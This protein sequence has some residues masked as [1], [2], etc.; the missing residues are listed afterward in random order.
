M[1][2]DPVPILVLAFILVWVLLMYVAVDVACDR[3]DEWVR[4]VAR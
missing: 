1:R 3:L 4:E 2:P